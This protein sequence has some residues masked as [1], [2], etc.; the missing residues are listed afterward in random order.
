MLKLFLQKNHLPCVVCVVVGVSSA[1]PTW[2]ARCHSSMPPISSA[3]PNVS[4]LTGRPLLLLGNNA[5]IVH[6]LR[7]KSFCVVLILQWFTKFRHSMY[8]CKNNCIISWLH[9]IFPLKFIFNILFMILE[10]ASQLFYS[11][12]EITVKFIL[13]V[14][15]F[16]LN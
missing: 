3:P 1:G 10:S 7:Q 12:Y 6:Y 16:L 11:L 9:Y 14:L 5:Y 15:C 13:N 2:Q 8:L 4:R